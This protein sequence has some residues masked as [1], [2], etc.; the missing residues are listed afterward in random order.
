M[1]TLFSIFMLIFI[2]WLTL[3]IVPAIL[4]FTFSLILAILQVLLIQEISGITIVRSGTN[5]ML[6]KL[7]G[8]Y[9]SAEMSM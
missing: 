8:W 7:H 4:G 6:L 2:V 9:I 3:K 5:T 1:S